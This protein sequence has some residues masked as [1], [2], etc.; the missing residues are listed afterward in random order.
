MAKMNHIDSTRPAPP[1]MNKLTTEYWNSKLYDL[2]FVYKY[3][4]IQNIE[5]QE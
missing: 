2:E 1:S 5:S 3:F 4:V